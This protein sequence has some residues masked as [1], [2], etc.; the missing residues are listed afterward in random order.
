MVL[1]TLR[2]SLKTEQFIEEEVKENITQAEIVSLAMSSF[3][4][5][6]NSSRNPVMIY[7]PSGA[8][9]KGGNLLESTELYASQL[10]DEETGGAEKVLRVCL[11]GS[12]AVGKSCI[13]LRFVQGVF[14]EQYD[15]TI[16]DYFRKD[17]SVDGQIVSLDILDT[18]G[19]EDFGALKAA[20]YRKKDGF[21]L[22]FSLDMPNTLD[23]LAKFHDE[24]SKFYEVEGVVPPILI[25]GNKLDLVSNAEAERLLAKA[26]QDSKEWDAVD[27]I[28]ASA[29]TGM[30]IEATFA[31]MVRAIRRSRVKVPVKKRRSWCDLL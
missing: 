28:R 3:D 1:L 22:V 7:L 20:W 13:A 5:F 24:L 11:L 4:C 9:F 8:E 18:A 27:V 10:L 23:D 2:A 29:K 26:N 25:V 16:E 6:T 30:N 17:A 15:P 31:N 21:I 12:G 19:Q 14:N